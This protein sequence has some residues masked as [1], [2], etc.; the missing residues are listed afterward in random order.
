MKNNKRRI[1]EL[2]KNINY[3]NY[4]YYILNNPIITNYKYDILLKKLINLENKYNYKY[5]YSPTKKLINNLFT[6]KKKIKHYYKMYSINNVYNKDELIKWLNNINKKLSI[7]DNKNN[8]YICELKYDGLAISLI[9]K[10]GFLKQASTRGNGKY[11]NNILKNILILK[12]IP[13]F[14]KEIKDIKIFDIK[15]EIVYSKKNFNYLNKIK[16]KNKLNPF[17][18]PRNA[19]NGVIHN[20]NNNDTIYNKK[21][22]FIPYFIYTN[23]K[24]FNYKFNNQYLSIKF[25]DKLFFKFQKKSYKLCKN[26]KDIINFIN[27]WEKNINKSIYPIDGIVIKINDFNI[28]KKIKY[29]NIFHKWCIAYKFKDKVYETTL[30]KIDY[31]IGKSGI[32]VPIINFTPIVINGTI[33]RKAS[34]YN[35]NIFFKHNLSIGDKI[36]IKKSGNIIPK[37]V[38]NITNKKNKI[39]KF[40]KYC[41]SCK[42]LLNKINNKIYCLNKD[43]CNLQKLEIFKHFISKN[44]MDIKINKNILEKLLNKKIIKSIIDFYKLTIKDLIRLNV[45]E[46]ES[47]KIINSIYKSKNKNISNVIYSLSIP[48]IGFYMSKIIG[49]KYKTISDFIYDI[50]NNIDKINIGDKRFNQIKIFFNKNKI[51]IIKKLKN[52]G[53]NI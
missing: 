32:I 23:N 52:I 45:T 17:S 18:N 3:H 7:T 20:I 12:K 21:L 22:D 39:V 34:L 13:Y 26:Y 33:I 53:F 14:F 43:K 47:N 16:I 29:N 8:N 49:N 51:N 40:P 5:K 9:Y 46:K 36:F 42:K 50:N 31:T 35:S 28:Q 4:R 25:L 24:K 11:G 2:S 19:A 15:G 27:Y 1:I 41:P 44:A 6:N 37:L 48:N 10:Y 30:K 38:K